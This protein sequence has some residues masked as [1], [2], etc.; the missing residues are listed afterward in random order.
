MVATVQIT[1]INTTASESN[2]VL[3]ERKKISKINTL[4]PSDANKK[5]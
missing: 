3:T 1:P 5:K 2:V 4:N